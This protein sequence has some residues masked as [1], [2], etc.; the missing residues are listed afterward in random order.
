MGDAKRRD[1]TARQ[2]SDPYRDVLLEELR[3]RVARAN[4]EL[5]DLLGS[6]APAL[7][8]TS[9]K[10]RLG[11]QR[12]ARAGQM[13]A[14]EVFDGDPE[15]RPPSLQISRRSSNTARLTPPPG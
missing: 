13:I 15:G 11:D 5:D 12:I 4:A 14:L 7:D 2:E 3:L 10:E 9:T 8:Q 6:P 1:I